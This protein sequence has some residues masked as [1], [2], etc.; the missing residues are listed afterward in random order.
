MSRYV[1]S[2]L[3]AL[4]I[5]TLLLTPVPSFAQGDA[6]QPPTVL[7][8]G[9]APFLEPV[10]P[11]NGGCQRCVL[12][13][14]EVPPKSGNFVWLYKCISVTPSIFFNSA[15]QCTPVNG[16][17]NDGCNMSDFCVSA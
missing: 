8:E 5:G 11:T 9:P 10:V 14:Y 2:T 4:A 1:F 15:R 3:S 12:Q 6:D 16:T 17:D 13:E 7:E